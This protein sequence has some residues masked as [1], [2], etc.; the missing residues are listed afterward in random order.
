M[1]TPN[2]YA[3]GDMDPF[4]DVLPELQHNRAEVL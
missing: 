3:R 4:P 1:P 2:L